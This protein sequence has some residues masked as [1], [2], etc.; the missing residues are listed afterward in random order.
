MADPN[1]EFLMGELR[2][3]PNTEFLRQQ[4][5]VG[6]AW[7]APSHREA[8]SLS[9]AVWHGL[10]SSATG[11]ALR[12]KLPDQQLPENAPWY[13]RLPSGAASMLADL[14]LS[15]VAAVPGVIGG[16]AVG[17]AVPVLGT[18]AGAV[19]GGGAAA[20]AAPMAL[21]DAL[22]TAYGQNHARDWND[23]WEI[24]KSALKGGA[25]GAVIGGATMGAGRVVGAALPAAVGA[26]ARGAAAT[27][28]E[29]IAMTGT[30]AAL[31]GHMP[32][33]Q[34]FMDNAILLGGLKA[35]VRIAGKLRQ[36]YAEAGKRP[37]EVAAEMG[38][39]PV[40]KK[41]ILARIAARDGDIPAA[42]K[43]LALA[44]RVK[45]AIEADPRPEMLTS[46]F[47][48]A[49]K[50][51]PAKIVDIL[52]EQPL[53][54]AEYVVDS[55]SAAAIT[56][57]VAALYEP[58]IAKQTRGEVADK[59][60]AAAGIKRLS[61]SALEAHEIGAAENAAMLWA[62]AK[63][64]RDVA[65]SA[66][67]KMQELSKTP[68]A[69]WT[70]EQ[71]VTAYAEMERVQIA[72]RNMRG[73]H[74]EV[75]R[76]MHILRTIKY[77]RDF[78][79]EAEAFTRLL[80]KSSGGDSFQTLAHIVALIK[81]PAQLAK[82]AEQI[83]KATTLEK[84]LEVWKAAILSG[85]L[86]HLA[87][88]LGNLTKFAVEIPESLIRTTLEA[89]QRKHA[90]DP[91]NMAE[92][93]A[94]ILSPFIGIKM[95][96]KDALVL[97]GEVWRGAGEHLEKGDV[98]RHANEGRV[99]HWVRAPFRA[100]QVADVLFRTVAERG[101][102]YELATVRALKDGLHPETAE[103]RERVV[104]YTNNP[105]KGL[106]IGDATV[107]LREIKQAGGEAVFSQRLGPKLEHV[108]AVMAGTP[109]QFVMPFFR[110]PVNLFS[111]ALQHSPFFMFSP[112]WR[113]EFSAGGAERAKATTKVMVGGAMSLLA[114]ELV[115]DGAI[116]GGGMFDKEQRAT[117]VAAGWQPYSI[118]IGDKY[119]SYQR[120]EPVSKVIGL[121]ADM[122]EMSDKSADDD[123]FK[124]W[125][126]ATALFGN[127][128]ISTTY[129]SG[130]SGLFNA[131]TDPERY[132]ENWY[133][134]YASS[135]VPKLIGQTAAL[136]DPHKRE[137]EGMVD[138]IQSQV[139]FLREK[140]MPK[141]DIWG[142]K[143]KADRLGW[144]LPIAA[145]E[146]TQDKVKAEAVRLELAIANVQKFIT[147]P[148]IGG[149]KDRRI[150]LEP[151]QR[152]LLKAISGKK[153]MDLLVPM[154]NS[155]DWNTI[156]DFAKA[157][158]IKK[159]VEETRKAGRYEAL[160]PDSKERLEL[161]TKMLDNIMRQVMEVTPGAE[162]APEKKR[163][164]V[165]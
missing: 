13:H 108:Q 86:T 120:I 158:I 103:F 159:V 6:A 150:D 60:T 83:T 141:R 26:T 10:Q 64:Y 102:A 131:V 109:M 70:I 101:R 76:A 77:D 124:V 89:G 85:P 116:T 23:V 69:E 74:A 121:V 152:D 40:L 5:S 148:G 140:L 71:K 154:V 115:K 35:S 143:M 62:R 92:Y 130:L 17:S 151:E 146:V 54:K 27:G 110:T 21:R 72:Y 55:D 87:N 137:V 38:L 33:A 163:K 53:V 1:T 79:G 58:E 12:G 81:D 97:V 134:Q 93:K 114:Y 135:L 113:G 80:E 25:K 96:M 118:K 119:Y 51:G 147:E 19:V 7:L 37:E 30:A 28:A 52:I 142:D 104:D 9:A 145:S 14:P 39:D 161:R 126:A 127:A 82:F 49:V 56:R 22:M 45:A 107:T 164:K 61:G 156:P 68:E 66:V 46:A 48:D 162:P 139:P 43:P 91:M 95:G 20:F 165:D 123:K 18:A 125:L 111:W 136:I 32:T 149:A 75:G 90:G 44:E 42:Y 155:P 59:A 100:L 11:L 31:E 98:Y 78:L 84:V 105:E 88:L 15:V 129:M 128:T 153:A 4:L 122:M 133:E 29:L 2:T 24:T 132:A 50:D 144:I 8:A 41:D 57:G 73:G 138:S 3:D 65:A 67:K 36:I 47:A 34:E 106:A 160:P 157:E 63:V 99:G 117:K 112:R 94:K 16:G